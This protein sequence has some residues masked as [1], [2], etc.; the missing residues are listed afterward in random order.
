MKTRTERPKQLGKLVEG[1][2]VNDEWTIVTIKRI[3]EDVAKMNAV[4]MTV[5]VWVIIVVIAIF[6]YPI[7]QVYPNSEGKSE[8]IDVIMIEIVPIVTE[9]IVI[10]VIVGTVI[11]TL[12]EE[13]KEE[14]RPRS[15]SE[16][17]R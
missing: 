9:T 15:H 5:E 1:N 2:V 17:K 16:S 13:M 4:E 8:W 14:T 10:V 11:E 7:R 6:A 3:V 12:V